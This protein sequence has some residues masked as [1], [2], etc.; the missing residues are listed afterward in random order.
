[1]NRDLHLERRDK[2]KQKY[3]I[4]TCWFSLEDEAELV[5]IAGFNCRVRFTRETFY[6]HPYALRK[7]LEHIKEKWATLKTQQ[8]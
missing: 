7:Y 4:I 8:L 5:S 3:P 2:M 1:M 6:E